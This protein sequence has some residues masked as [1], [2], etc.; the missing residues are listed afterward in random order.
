[1]EA[2][3][4]KT[5]VLARTDAI[6]GVVNIREPISTFVALTLSGFFVECTFLLVAGKARI[7]VLTFGADTAALD[8]LLVLEEPALSAFV[9][10]TGQLVAK[11]TLS[12][13]AR[14]TTSLPLC[15]VLA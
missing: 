8:A 4:V 7:L 15:A 9:T 2:C 1:M 13:I 6:L 3:S 5:D 12:A 10:L 14:A 11:C